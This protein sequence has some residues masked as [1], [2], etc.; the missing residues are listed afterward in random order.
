LLHASPS[1]SSKRPSQ[2]RCYLFD[3]DAISE[4]LMPRPADGYV[5]WLASIPRE[6]Q[7]TSAV[8]VGELYEGAF[9]SSAVRVTSTTSRRAC[10][11]P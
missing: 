6:E 9:R 7:F 5:K 1:V 4:V 10:C 11:R 3:P 8:V 2:C